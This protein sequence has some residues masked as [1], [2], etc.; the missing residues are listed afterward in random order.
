MEPAGRPARAPRPPA[1]ALAVATPAPAAAGAPAATA[2]AGRGSPSSRT[3]GAIVC[4]KPTGAGGRPGG[5]DPSGTAMTAS[6]AAA[7][8]SPETP[9]QSRDDHGGASAPEVFGS[10]NTCAVA[11]LGAPVAADVH[12]DSGGNPTTLDQA[13]ATVRSTPPPPLPLPPSSSRPGHSTAVPRTTAPALVL[14]FL[15]DDDVSSS[16][17]R[18]SATWTTLQQQC[19]PAAPASDASGMGEQHELAGV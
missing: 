17:P 1:A 10:E 7:P 16:M 13:P 9:G 14:A 19:S 6:A 18:A 12:L 15:R 5:E 8:R 2:G 3:L 4:G 11:A